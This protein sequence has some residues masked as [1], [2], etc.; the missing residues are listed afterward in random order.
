MRHASRMASV[1]GH[2]GAKKLIASL[3][4]EKDEAELTAK[5][6]QNIDKLL[7]APYESLGSIEG[8]LE[9][10]NLH[11]TPRFIVYEQRT[12]KAVTCLFGQFREELME[13]IKSSLEERVVVAGRLYRNSKG[14]PVR[15]KLR[16]ASDLQVFGR[17]LKILRMA[18]LRGSDRDFT[19]GLSVQ[20]YVRRMRG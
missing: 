6:V 8:H 1:I 18:D 11:A 17:D 3:P 20:E 16:S 7:Q 10:I 15:I 9:G 14:E 12:G 5:A 13:K 2:E 19:G 4:E